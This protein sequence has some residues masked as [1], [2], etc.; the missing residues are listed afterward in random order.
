MQPKPEFFDHRIQMF[1]QLKA[2]HDEWVKGESF[3]IYRS[4]VLTYRRQLSPGKR[5]PSPCLMALSAKPPAGRL[6]QWTSQ[7]RFQNLYLSVLSS[8]R[9]FYVLSIQGETML[10]AL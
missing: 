2:E 8:P 10:N 9:S 7:R 6:R 4:L 1:E 5:L 3:T